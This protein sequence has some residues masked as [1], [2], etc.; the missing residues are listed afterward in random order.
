MSTNFTLIKYQLGTNGRYLEDSGER[1]ASSFISEETL[2][3]LIKVAPLAKLTI[4]EEDGSDKFS[5]SDCLQ[6]EK[7]IEVLNFVKNRFIV[8]IK[9]TEISA[10]ESND[11]SF[12]ET[13]SE[14]RS[15]T[16]LYYLL[17]TKHAK[18]QSDDTVI[19]K[20]G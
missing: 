14:F 6:N 16:N 11:E 20:L 9:K 1:I 4:Y 19:V 15:I 8:M 18:Y 17:E 7:I 3:D 2:Q 5:E 12:I 10:I 13:I